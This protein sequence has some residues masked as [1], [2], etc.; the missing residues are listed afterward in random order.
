MQRLSTA[1]RSVRAN[2][3]PSS[4]RPADGSSADANPERAPARV[5]NFRSRSEGLALVTDHGGPFEQRALPGGKVNTASADQL[6][7]ADKVIAAVRAKLEGNRDVLGRS[8]HG[9]VKW[10]IDAKGQL[11]VEFQPTL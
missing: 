10:R 11:E 8:R 4:R 5:G 2:A 9:L 7:Q 6:R 3:L 1:R